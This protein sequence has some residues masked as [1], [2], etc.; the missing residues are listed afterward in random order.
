LFWIKKVKIENANGKRQGSNNLE[1]F[2]RPY[3]EQGHG[4]IEK[5]QE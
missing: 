3:I 5:H 4:E 1:E 2:H